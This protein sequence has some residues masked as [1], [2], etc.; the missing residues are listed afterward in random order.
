MTFIKNTLCALIILMGAQFAYS[1]EYRMSDPLPVDNAYK[2]GKL[3]NGMT[4]YI[5]KYNNPAKRAEF[6]IVHNVGSLQENDNQRGLAHFLEHM[7]FNGTKN[8]PKKQLLNYFAGIGVKFGANINAYTSMDRTVYNLSAVPMERSSVIDSALLVLHDWSYYISCE[9]AEIEAER[10]VIREEWRRGDDSRTRMMKAFFKYEQTGSRFAQRD[11]IG[12]TAII[13]SFVPPTLVDFYHKWYRPDLQAIVVVGDFDVADMEKRIIKRFSSIPK[14]VNP[15]VRESYTIPTNQKPIIGY[16]T[17]PESSVFSVRITTKIPY[18]NKEAKQTNQAVY[19]E[20]THSIFLEIFKDRVAA[21]AE[22]GDSCFKVAVPVFGS[23]SY[24]MKTFTV[25]VIPY[26]KKDLLKGA[27]GVLTESERLIQ[28]GVEKAEFDNA[29]VRISRQLDKDYNRMKKPTSGDL[30]NS[31]VENFTRSIPLITPQDYFNTAKECLKRITVEDFN[32]SLP[33]ILTKENR[34]IIFVMPQKDKKLLPSEEEVIKA[35]EEISATE[36]ERFIPIRKKGIEFTQKLTPVPVLASKVITEKDIRLPAGKQLDSTIEM[37]LS[38]G[39]KVI[40]KETHTDKNNVSFIAYKNGGY[41]LNMN[42][43]DLKILDNFKTFYLVNGLNKPELT[44]W[45]QGRSVAVKPE[46]TYRNSFFSGSFTVKDS[47]DFFKLLNL[48]FT[49]ISVDD[50]DVNNMKT[51]MLKDLSEPKKAINFYNDSISKLRYSFNPTEEKFTAEYIKSITSGKLIDLYKSV[52]SNPKG[53]TFVFS[54]PLSANEAKP[55]IEKYI[56]SITNQSAASADASAQ[57]PVYREPKL[58]T[59]DIQLKYKAENLLSTKASIKREY[60]NKMD[61]TA[62][63]YLN[64]KVLSYIMGERYM[65]SIRE[66]R[67]ATYHVGVTSNIYRYPESIVDITIEFDTDPKLVDEL[68]NVVQSEFETF[69]KSG[70]T[71]KE[72]TE[73]KL[74]LEK[75]YQDR[76]KESYKWNEAIVNALQGNITF[77]DDEAK[78]LKT[79]NAKSLQDLAKNILKGKNRMTFVFEPKL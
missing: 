42:V 15:S 25:S 64:A 73:V 36:T 21:A 9:P 68:L 55:L 41:S 29:V 10:G 13:N 23:L 18:P 28:H 48:Y 38:N 27:K 59:G 8:Y 72:I 7:A 3:E 26:N 71:E 47:L 19:E 40:W 33:K 50:R 5:R 67:G 12:D 16:I 24:A 53:F 20:L 79:I 57:K 30:V 22:R 43:L 46:I 35:C 49:D 31:V 62:S 4:Y 17:D 52:Y 65:A 61:Y 78:L 37:T 14:A 69:A 63:N 51:R 56:A 70:P 1:Q 58:N 75:V 32:K 45:L 77:S 39:A 66:Q 54:G 74:Y 60:Y 2:I 6:F 76:Q 34:V 11:V 44:K